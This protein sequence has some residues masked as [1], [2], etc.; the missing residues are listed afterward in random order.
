[1]RPDEV[2]AEVERVVGRLA[3]IYER[4]GALAWCHTPQ[5]ALHDRTPI[6]MIQAGEVGELRAV[7]DQL[8]DGAYL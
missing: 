4:D 6:E 5:R 3:D 7:V 2:S 1:M 8:L